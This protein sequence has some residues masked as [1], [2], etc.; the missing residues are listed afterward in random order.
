MGLKEITNPK[1]NASPPFV[2]EI[3]KQLKKNFKHVKKL[4]TFFQKNYQNDLWFNYFGPD[5]A[6]DAL[7]DKKGINDFKYFNIFKK[8]SR[9]KRGI[10]KNR[11]AFFLVKK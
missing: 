4:E 5:I 2:F 6:Y 11:V 1:Q 3:H 7:N 10:F 9:K 8:L